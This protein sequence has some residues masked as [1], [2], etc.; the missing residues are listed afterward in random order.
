MKVSYFGELQQ[1]HKRDKQVRIRVEIDH[2]PATTHSEFKRKTIE[3]ERLTRRVYLLLLISQS[4]LIGVNN[5]QNY[6][7]AEIDLL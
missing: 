5:R 6:I 1:G 7:L 3:I 4:H 2:Y